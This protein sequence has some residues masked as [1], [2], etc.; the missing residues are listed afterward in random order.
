MKYTVTV[1]SRHLDYYEVE[2]DSQEEA[3]DKVK[4][5]EGADLVHSEFIENIPNSEEVL[6][7]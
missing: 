1:E 4:R 2:A 5:M 3:I 6:T 7:E